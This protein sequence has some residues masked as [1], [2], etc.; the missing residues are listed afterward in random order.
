MATYFVRMSNG[1]KGQGAKRRDYIAREKSFSSKKIRQELV[2]SEDF[3]LP[4]WAGNSREFFEAADKYERNN[5]I[6]FRQMIIALPCELS[7]EENIDIARNIV[8]KIVG[9]TKAGTWAIHSKPAFTTNDE[10]IHMHL[11]FSDRIQDPAISEKSKE[12]YF[13]RYNSK[14]PEKG[15]YQK[16]ASLNAGYHKN[17][18]MNQI[19]EQ[20]A[21]AINEGYA[22]AG[23]DIRISGKTLEEQKAEAISENDLD[24]AKLLDRKP[25]RHIKQKHWR[26]M[27]KIF[28]ES[29]AIDHSKPIPIQLNDEHWDIFKR[30]IDFDINTAEEL[31]NRL[32]YQAKKLKYKAN[33]LE[34]AAK[35]AL[36]ETEEFITGTD[37]IKVINDIETK[38][39]I[40]IN[41]NTAYVNLYN[42]IYANKEMRSFMAMNFVTRG[43]VK[44]L[45]KSKSKLESYFSKK[46][47]LK[48]ENRLTPN[49]EHRLNLLIRSTQEQI[50][51]LEDQILIIKNKPVAKKRYDYFLAR[52][53]KSMTNAREKATKKYEEAKIF[54]LLK[55]ETQELKSNISNTNEQ[56]PEP[57]ILKLIQ[58]INIKEPQK[59]IEIINQIKNLIPE[60]FQKQKE[61]TQNQNI[62][63]EE[64]YEKHK[65]TIQEQD[66]ER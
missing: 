55:K 47:N 57:K 64:Q 34:K 15:G 53:K 61:K 29:T 48:N 3:N 2:A 22:K 50:K 46:R 30:V 63:N 20:I 38:S 62:K 12:L 6:V 42:N 10:N 35:A 65:K 18:A 31:L 59:A 43:R 60:E 56:I 25:F 7:H 36:I 21:D 9:N 16:D 33:K 27:Q 1:Y 17:P 54:K 40:R 44:K 49:E 45:N 41:N 66:K 26:K 28:E 39:N 58:E 13:K 37:L 5:G 52:L 32:E 8:K 24:K 11:M 19:R 23:I 51:Y 14:N 4:S